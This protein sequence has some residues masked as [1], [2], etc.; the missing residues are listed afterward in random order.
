[1]ERIDDLQLKGLKIIQNPKGF[2]FG[3]DAVL[4]ANHVRLKPGD[5]VVDLG[6]GTGIIPLLLA[7]K[8]RTSTFQ[9]LEL[10]ESVVD[11]AQRSVALNQLEDRIE[12]LQGDLKAPERVFPKSVYDVVTANPPYMHREGLVNPKDAK[13]ISRHEVAC[14]LEDVVKGAATLLRTHG[15]FYMVHRPNRLVDIL[16]FMR[17][18][19]LEPKGLTMIQ[20]KTG[21]APNLLI[22]EGRKG[23]GKEL[24]IKPPL[25]I[26]EE[27][28]AYTKETLALYNQQNL[29]G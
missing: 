28:G 10:Q 5:R 16:F 29:E 7:G 15:R 23:A 12:I 6:T 17:S 9:G 3:I 21:K 4:L 19:G 8:S 22:V 1:M 13:A 25:I 27:S 14:D 18:H 11:M 26:Y 20:P 24:K 2:C